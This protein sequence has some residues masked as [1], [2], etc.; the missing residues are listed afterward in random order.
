[1]Q[2]AFAA[3]CAIAFAISLASCGR[4]GASTLEEVKRLQEAGSHAQAEELLREHLAAHPD[5]A[6][7]S[8]RRGL[9]LIALGRGSEAV[10]PLRKAL[11]S[12]EFGKQAALVLAG[13]LLTTRNFEAAM[14]TADRVLETEP[15]NESALVTRARAAIGALKSEEALRSIDALAKLKPDALMPRVL[16]A[17]AVSLVPERLAESEKLYEE[18][19]S[20]DWGDDEA[21]PGRACLTRAR[22]LHDK[23]HDAAR[24]GALALQCAEKY[25]AL[26][27]IVLGTASLLDRLDRG[28][29][30]T[31]L[32]RAHFEKDPGNLALRAGLAQRLISEDEFA[33]AEQ[34]VVEEA[35][36]RNTAAGWSALASLRRRLRNPD[37]ALEA[38][39][40][41]IAAS[42]ADSE[43]EELCADRADLLLD[44]GRP[45]EAKDALDQIES[46]VYRNVIEGRLAEL[47]GDGQEALSKYSAALEQWPDNWSLR[48]RA[49]KVAFDLGDVDRALVELREVTR[50]APKETDAALQMA[51]I[52]LSRGELQEAYAFAMRHIAERGATG[53]DGHLVAA[54]AAAAARRGEEVSRVL[55]DLISRN[56]GKFAAAGL[57][58][59]ARLAATMRSPKEALDAL[60]GAV[61]KSQLDLSRPEHF[62]ALRQG[63]M[64]AS[65]ISGLGA[66][67]AR[68][69]AALAKAPGRA[70][71]LALR[72][73]LLAQAGRAEASEAVAAALAANADESLAH[74]ALGLARRGGGDTKGAVESFDRALALDATLSDAGYFAAQT[75][76]MSGDAAAAKQR[77]EQL[78]R[79]YPDHAGALNDLAWMLAEEGA[80]LER[81][82]KL[83]QYA[84]RLSGRAEMFDTFGYV[85]LKQE[86]YE[87]AARAFRASLDKN[88]AYST[89]RYHLG[90]AL[91]RSG[92]AA[93]AKKELQLAVASGEF[94]ELAAAKTELARLEGSKQ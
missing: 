90:L 45:E 75:L 92:D 94:P 62:V 82:G 13:T 47:R 64:L 28:E 57:A 76:A 53:P 21:G 41:A 55:A 36:K 46:A 30:G 4:D 89:A 37:G 6:E 73:L 52:H 69:D 78:V 44:M 43:R 22:L 8:F 66:G 5:D 7:A 49:A 51:Q 58:E 83:A 50:H 71:L 84:T 38:I 74:L 63:A 15:D 31:Q 81:A 11:D 87:E 70:D 10:F 42:Q 40:R 72:A 56:E 39:D 67:L 9:S 2:L 32:V 23:G 59:H 80:D 93:G 29:E 14:E 68:V 54:R 3:A 26:P 60:D 20:A 1:V 27:T 61:E 19:E 77:L 79:V 33:E 12:P 34:L 16:R 18:L 25:Q 88:G 65:E 24:A 48:T 17:E 86:R 35:E 91:E 85:R